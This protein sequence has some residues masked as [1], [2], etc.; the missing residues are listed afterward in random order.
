MRGGKIE[1]SGT[2]QQVFDQPETP[3]VMDFLGN[4]NV[5]HGRVENGMAMLGALNIAY[6]EYP[7]SESKKATAYVRPHE[8]DIQRTPFG[9]SCLEVR[10]IQLNPAGSVAKVRVFSE[11]FGLALNVDLNLERYSEL[12]LNP[13]DTVFVAAKRV[14]VFMPD[15]VDFSI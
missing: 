15:A 1:Q 8:L 5:F 4:V 9:D 11:Q 2:P 3:F 10:V 7:H 12:R 14:R 13:G 6:P